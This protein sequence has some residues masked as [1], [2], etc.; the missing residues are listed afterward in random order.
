MAAR[1][2]YLEIDDEI[3]SAAARI[4]DAESSRIAV[5]L[6][7]GS[8]VATSR[9][10]FRLLSRDALTHEKR[11]SIVS[12]D[13]ATRA[14]AA[15]A[16]LPVFS[17]VAEYESSGA[18]AED[19]VRSGTGVPVVPAVAASPPVDLT[20]PAAASEPVSDGTLGLGDTVRTTVPRDLGRAGDRPADRVGRAGSQPKATA[21]RPG[22]PG[23]FRTPWLIG[24]AILALALLVAGVGVYL[25]LPSATIVVTPRAEP[26]AAAPLTVIADTS[27]TQP[28]PVRGVVP[29]SLIPVPISASNT[30]PA[31]GKRTALTKATG[32]VRFDNLDPTSTNRIDGGSIIR[33]D[34][35][36][37]FR[38][39]VT[40]IVPSGNLVSDGRGGIKDVPGTANVK[41]TAVDGG[42]EGNVGAGTINHV[43]SGENG[44]FLKVT[45]PEATSGGAKQ[46]FLRIIQ[47]D[48]DGAMAA[49]NTSLQAAFTA[50]IADPSLATGGA[51]VFPAT[52]TLGEPTPDVPTDTLVGQEVP[53]FTLTLSA[54]G[55]VV[56]VDTAPVTT[57]ADAQLRAA[58]KPGHE[59]V[60]GSEQIKVGDAQVVGQSVSFPVTASAEQIAVLDPAALRAAVLGKPIADAKAILAQYGDVRLTVSPDWS[61]TVPGFESRVNVTIDHPV[62]IETP[63]PTG[64]APTTPAASSGSAAPAASRSAAP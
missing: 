13:P 36:V 38:T 52:G 24:G 39:D 49:L 56:A 15:S 57:I 62:R 5:V 2:V 50:A 42:T 60:A 37:Q 25:L 34:S 46:E 43:P 41:V 26:V 16:G 27:A 9:I 6:P 22:A 54:S 8:R 31:T 12:G 4:R 59:L 58:V 44:I 45:N 3:T 11:L 7:Y 18:G 33:T 63:A 21:A 19:D 14:L 35:G 51:T 20:T 30:F 40:V 1:I 29:A 53:T 17:S 48:V 47:A 61:G 28:D 10:N 32:T 64:A 55:T 23:W